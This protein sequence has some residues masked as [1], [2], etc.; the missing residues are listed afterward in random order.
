LGL[1]DDASGS[2]PGDTAWIVRGEFGRS[3]TP[4]LPWGGVVLMPYI[5]EATGESILQDPTVPD[6]GSVHA[7][8]YGA[9][10]RFNLTPPSDQM[11]GGYGFI[12]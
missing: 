7:T 9:G 3:F 12:E 5:F 11:P 10:M 1:V 2:L 8:D 6:I 4:Q